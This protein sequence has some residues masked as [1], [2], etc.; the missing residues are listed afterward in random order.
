[1][2]QFPT[3]VK[4]FTSKI[5]LVDTVYADHVN[6]LQDEVR[7]LEASIGTSLLLSSYTGSFTQTASWNTLG[8][9]LNNMERGLLNGVAGSVYLNKTGDTVQ[10][11]AGTV[12]LVIRSSSGS[13]SNLVE[14]R[15]SSNA[16]GFRVD[17]AG[18]PYVGTQALVYVG[19]TA[20]TSLTTDVAA[21]INVA[22]VT[23]SPFLLAGM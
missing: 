15:T 23:V 17:S 22:T 12:G 21:A 7:A 13:S 2:A 4:T 14:T 3:S 20:Y 11:P 16:L 1:M 5:D 19:G 9:R 8:D 6:T 18:L 10:A